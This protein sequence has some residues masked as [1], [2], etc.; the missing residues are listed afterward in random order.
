LVLLVDRA[1]VVIVGASHPDGSTDQISTVEEWLWPTSKKDSWWLGD[2]D[3][4]LS[5]YT[6]RVV[7]GRHLVVQEEFETSQKKERFQT[8]LWLDIPGCEHGLRIES[9]GVLEPEVLVS[10]LPE[11]VCRGRAL[12]VVA[13]GREVLMTS[14]LS[15][16][17]GP[18][19]IFDNEDH[20]G[21]FSF[22]VTYRTMP[23]TLAE[24][25]ARLS[26]TRSSSEDPV[27]VPQPF[28][29]HSTII[30]PG[31]DGSWT[32]YKWQEGT[33]SFELVTTDSAEG[34]AEEFIEAIRPIEQDVYIEMLKTL[35]SEPLPHLQSY[36]PEPTDE[37]YN[38]EP[39]DTTV[40]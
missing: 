15:N 29:G 6:D 25:L 17:H 1:Q 28:A 19:L 5:T 32:S 18:T 27:P 13:A 38:T 23:K 35:S 8:L 26:P 30:T 10:T 37:P 34:L 22:S 21:R 11:I 40:A 39:A 31:I 20:S 14:R 16:A 33:V 9:P 12:S 24:A 7:N 3:R 2:G 36:V 4:E